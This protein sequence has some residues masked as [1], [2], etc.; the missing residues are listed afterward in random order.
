MLARFVGYRDYETFCKG[1]GEVQSNIVMNERLEAEEMKI[2]HTLRLTWKPDRS[3]VIRHLS[4]GLFE[5]MERENTKLR[6]GD[7]FECHLFIKHEPLYINNIQR[8]G[9]II[10]ETYII[11]SKDGITFEAVPSQG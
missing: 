8:D 4:H 1:D 5:I 7:I 9:K 6:T 11:G 3:C 10:I 2:G